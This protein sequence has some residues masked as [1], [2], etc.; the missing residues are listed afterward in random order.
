VGSHNRP[1]SVELT[2]PPLAA[3]VLKREAGG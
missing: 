3:V 1:W 2:L